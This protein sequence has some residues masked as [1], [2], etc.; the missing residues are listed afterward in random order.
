MESHLS[1]VAALKRAGDVA[2]PPSSEYGT[3]QPVSG[4]GFLT[5]VP[6]TVY[7]VPS[8]L[9]TGEGRAGPRTGRGGLI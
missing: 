6:A 9:G 7:G 4:L 1:R 8:W 2:R 3:Y 5:N